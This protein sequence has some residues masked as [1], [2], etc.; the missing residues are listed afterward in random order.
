M[1]SQSFMKPFKNGMT[2]GV[3]ISVGTTF[4]SYPIQEN[5]MVSYNVL[6]YQI[7]QTQ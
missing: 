2:V 5:F 4:E 3:G 1:L 6:S 7:F